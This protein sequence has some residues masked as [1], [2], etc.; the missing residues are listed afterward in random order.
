MPNIVGF[1]DEQVQKLPDWSKKLLGIENEVVEKESKEIQNN[2]ST[3]INN[4]EVN[5]N[6]TINVDGSKDPKEVSRLIDQKLK[7]RERILAGEVGVNL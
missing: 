7:T 1:I 4:T 5:E 6:I 2:N 3:N